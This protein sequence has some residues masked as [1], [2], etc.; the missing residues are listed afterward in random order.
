VRSIWK[1]SISFGLVHIPV[2]LYAATEDRSVHFHLLHRRCGTRIRYRR[3]CPHCGVEPEE[4]DIARGY[5]WAPGQY[6]IVEDADLES[7]PLPTARTVA[8]QAFVRLDSIDPI[9][10]DRTYFL[11]P[12]DGGGRAYGLLREAMRQTGRAA[13]A[14]VALRHKESLACVR[15]HGDRALVLETMHRADEIR[16]PGVLPGLA[17]T[18]APADPGE[19]ALAVDL[20]DRL[21]A[22][23]EP[24]RY[25]D[26]YR[27]AL[28]AMIEERVRGRRITVPP[29]PPQ[30][31]VV[32]LMEALRASLRQVEQA[33]PVGPVPAPGPV[34]PAPAPRP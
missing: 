23:F 14:R 3:W 27:E 7:L 19:L 33:A 5:P 18:A 11:E 9:Y 12:A 16:D 21:T 32:D 8:I 26:R 25:P 30:A 24:E 17:G 10:F 22:P 15:V 2:R 34:E 4:G 6:V 1:G 13:V 28:L 29:A 20:I 31:P